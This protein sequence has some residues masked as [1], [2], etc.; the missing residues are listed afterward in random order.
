MENLKVG[1]EVYYV[2][3]RSEGYR[4]IEKVGRKYIHIKGEGK[5][6]KDTLR[7]VDYVGVADSIYLT[8]EEYDTIQRHAKLSQVL[9]SQVS[10]KSLNLETLEQLYEIVGK[11]LSEK[12]KR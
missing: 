9:G 2:G 4:N 7:Q 10:Y 3:W 12:T 1:Q 8:K 6:H 11:A 5:F